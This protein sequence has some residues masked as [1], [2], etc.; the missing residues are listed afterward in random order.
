MEIFSRRILRDETDDRLAE[1]RA[2][3]AIEDVAFYL[4]PVLA[5]DGDVAAIV[6]SLLQRGAQLA[7]GSQLRNP[8]LDRLALTAGNNFQVIDGQIVLRFAHGSLFAFRCSLLEKRLF[9]TETR[10]V[11]EFLRVCHRIQMLTDVVTVGPAR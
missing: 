1:C 5:G 8:A 4:G 3:A 7:L 10:S 11:T 6:E 2:V 9:T